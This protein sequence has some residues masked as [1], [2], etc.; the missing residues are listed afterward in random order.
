MKFIIF[1]FFSLLVSIIN[2]QSESYSDPAKEYVLEILRDTQSDSLYPQ[3]KDFNDLDICKV[4]ADFNTD[5]IKDVAITN[6]S[7]GGAHY[8]QWSIYLG[9]ENGKFKYFDELWF[10]NGAIKIEK[11]EKGTSIIYVY[12]RDVINKGDLIVYSLSVKG[13][14]EIERKNINMEFSEDYI[15]INEDAKLYHKLFFNQDISDSCLIINEYLRNNKI[16]WKKSW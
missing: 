3:I 15:P 1:I 11:L 13:I 14:K 2:A 5:G 4:Y 10:H 8:W 7:L 12:F 16:L 6:R 9:L